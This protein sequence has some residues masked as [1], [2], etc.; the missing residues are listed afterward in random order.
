[1]ALE[2]NAKTFL[3]PDHEGWINARI[4]SKS[5]G[6]CNI[7]GDISE[8]LGRLHVL[9]VF[10]EGPFGQYLDLHLPVTIHG[11]VLHSI[12]KR[13]IS[14]ASPPRDDEMWFGLGQRQHRFGQVEF[15]LCSGLKM[16]KLP[17][18]LIRATYTPTENSLYRRH[19]ENQP[20]Y[21][22][23]FKTFKQ[24]TDDQGED[25]L[26]MANLLIIGYILC[27]VDT[28]DRV[29]LWMFA[30]VDDDAAFKGFA[31]GSYVY[32]FTLMRIKN[33]IHKNLGSLKPKPSNE[34]DKKESKSKT[35]ESIGEGEGKPDSQ[36]ACPSKGNAKKRGRKNTESKLEPKPTMTYN[37]Q[38][39]LLSFQVCT[40]HCGLNT[41]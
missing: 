26:K 30:F 27:T 10:K 33:A 13:Q 24:L 40:D 1:M 9:E 37:L 4:N 7:L 16:G 12:L 28:R 41:Y 2:P 15:C 5:R 22:S 6:H 21:G 18:G 17:E 29:P 34:A 20:T 32:S 3:Y 25:A 14:N 23:L 38:G 19:F 8:I 11:K 39:F 36:N 31:W 35:I